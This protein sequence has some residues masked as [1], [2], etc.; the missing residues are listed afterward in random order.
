MFHFNFSLKINFSSEMGVCFVSCSMFI[1]PFKI[2]LVF[3]LHSFVKPT[4][5]RMK[6]WVSSA[7]IEEILK[8]T[9]FTPTHPHRACV[10]CSLSLSH[11][12]VYTTTVRSQDLCAVQFEPVTPPSVHYTTV[13]SQDLCTVQFEPATPPSVHYTTVRSQNLCTVQFEPV[14]P[15]SVHYTTVRSTGLVYSTV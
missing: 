1:E 2:T 8:S 12:Q 10:Q 7:I 4:E 9:N 5:T 13:R 11:L 6:G 15:P 3:L 14:T